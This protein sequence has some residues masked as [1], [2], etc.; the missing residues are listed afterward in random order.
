MTGITEEGITV[1]TFD[2]VVA[3]LEQKFK[4]ELCTPDALFRR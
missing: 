4:L 2:Q 1:K 3:S